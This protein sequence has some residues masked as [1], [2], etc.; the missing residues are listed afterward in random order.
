MTKIAHR[1]N[2]PKAKRPKGPT[3]LY[4]PVP[5]SGMARCIAH[6]GH[7]FEV[8]KVYRFQSSCEARMYPPYDIVRVYNEDFTEDS[9]GLWVFISNHHN[10]FRK[11]FEIVG[12]GRGS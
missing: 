12:E 3:Q 2:A 9:P 7:G 5:E 10:L 4:F 8:G 6:N 1:W 11:S